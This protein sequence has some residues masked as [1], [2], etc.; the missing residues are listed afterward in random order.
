MHVTQA[1]V[2]MATATRGNFIMFSWRIIIQGFQANWAESQHR[3]KMDDLDQRSVSIS[4]GR[5]L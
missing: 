3:Q 1:L 5:H 4:Q 2:F